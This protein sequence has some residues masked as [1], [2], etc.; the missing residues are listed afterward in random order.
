ML[1]VVL[2][3]P[4]SRRRFME[5]LSGAAAFSALGSRSLSTAQEAPAPAPAA[6][7]DSIRFTPELE[8]LVR[9]IET[10]PREKC[11]ELL[12]E[13]LKGGLAYRQLLSAAFLAAI[14]K[15]DS[16]HAVYLIHSAHQ[17]SLDLP[18]PERLLPLFWAIDHFKWQQLASPGP[19]LPPLAGPLPAA[20][21]AAA[22]FHAAM[23]R[24]DTDGAEKAIVA[25]ARHE[26]S[27]PAMEVLWH[28]GCR[29][30]GFI[31]HHAIALTSCWRVLDVIGWEQAEPVLRF[32]VRD[33]G[34]EDR[35]YP[36]N[37]TRSE[38]L[39]EKLPAGWAMGDTQPE[40]T[41]E[42]FAL[43]RQGQSVE[44]S[45]LAGQLLATRV[46]AQAVW[47]AVH[48]VAAEMLILHPGDAGMGGR[49][50]HVNTAANALHY[51]FR[52]TASSQNRLLILLQAVAWTADFV[53]AQ[54]GA[55]NLAETKPVDLAGEPPV[56]P[57][58]D[59]LSDVFASL[60][61]HE[62]RYDYQTRVGV[63][64]H[65]PKKADRAELARRVFSVITADPAA[66]D[67][68]AAAARHWLCR[69]AT[70]D[71]HEYKLPAAMFEDYR[72]VSAPWRP[73]LLAASTHWLHGPQSEDAAPVRQA[74][75]A[76][77]RI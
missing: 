46:G 17:T 50:L 21:N 69:K 59:V 44:A 2:A 24:L 71:A 52:T 38:K 1:I 76:L 33:L 74:R 68:Y 41:R 31:G 27:R 63:G 56:R 20:E 37:V 36:A 64:H 14:R 28:Y 57:A 34:R 77:S 54:L 8:P 48:V 60:P 16:A 23:K 26:G 3:M 13:K 6:E 19:S 66:A 62:Y 61:P 5:V 4:H 42:L 45:E 49:A 22:D 40:A 55:E 35:Y 58:A 9:L 51:A 30:C 18:Q 11:A 39:W 72:L 10:A 47:D 29:D 73:R 25:L 67:T 43:L 32:V 7:P 15:R 65:L 75:E 53:R 70:V 12:A